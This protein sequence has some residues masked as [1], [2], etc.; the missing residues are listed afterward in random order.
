VMLDF[1]VGHH[2]FVILPASTFQTSNRTSSKTP[3]DSH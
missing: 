1:R 2:L 3:D